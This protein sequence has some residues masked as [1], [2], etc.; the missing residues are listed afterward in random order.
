[1][2]ETENNA[3]KKL[4]SMLK[5]AKI[6]CLLRPV[7]VYSQHLLGLTGLSESTLFANMHCI[8]SLSHCASIFHR[9]TN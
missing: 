9:F 1:M 8:I 6:I 4:H 2:Q 3:Y 5:P 7:A